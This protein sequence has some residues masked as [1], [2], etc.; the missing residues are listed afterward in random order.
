MRILNSQVQKYSLPAGD[1][2][3]C[4]A[5]ISDNFHAPNHFSQTQKPYSF[6]KCHDSCDSVAGPVAARAGFRPNRSAVS[7]PAAKHCGLS[8]PEMGSRWLTKFRSANQI[9]VSISP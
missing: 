6:M 2:L 9:V 5:T 3:K 7:V 4:T 1:D 8:S